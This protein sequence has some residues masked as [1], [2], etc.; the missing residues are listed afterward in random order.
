MLQTAEERQSIVR[1]A[2]E[3]LDQAGLDNIA[4]VVGCGAP[5]TLES[6]KLCRDACE[7][8]ADAAL[9]VP[10][11]YYGEILKQNMNLL[12]QHFVDIAEASPIPV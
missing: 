8:G 9:I 3:A 2:R 4:I 7:A 5:S 10:S 12:E 11:G 6:V 1:A